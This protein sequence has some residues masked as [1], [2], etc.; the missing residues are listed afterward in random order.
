MYYH[1]RKLVGSRLSPFFLRSWSQ[2]CHCHCQPQRFSSLVYVVCTTR[3]LRCIVFQ[4]IL[5]PLLTSD[6]KIVAGSPNFSWLI[7]LLYIA[8][9]IYIAL[10][11]IL[12]FDFSFFAFPDIFTCIMKLFLTL[13]PKIITPV[14]RQPQC[15][16]VDFTITSVLKCIVLQ[17]AMRYILHSD[18]FFC[19]SSHIFIPRFLGWFYS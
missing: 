2:D 18:L 15:S 10:C 11:Y 1:I 17:L 16:L 5:S 3:A 12:H 4:C 14:S 7:S 6:P 13:D 9:L 8:V 19:N